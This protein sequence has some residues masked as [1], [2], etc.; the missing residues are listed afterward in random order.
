MVCLDPLGGA[1]YAKSIMECKEVKCTQD[2]DA[3][4]V[5]FA[6][7]LGRGVAVLPSS[8]EGASL[9]MALSAKRPLV[10]E[11]RLALDLLA[12]QA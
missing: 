10:A 8:T 9:Q 1:D 12:P 6:Y 7:N 2:S 11:H 3:A 4:E 5:L